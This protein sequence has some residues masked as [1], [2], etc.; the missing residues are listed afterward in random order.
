MDA[1][2]PSHEI[3]PVP[4]PESLG[5]FRITIAFVIISIAAL[6][7]A[8]FV[9]DRLAQRIGEDA[10]VKA[11]SHVASLQSELIGA[12][13]SQTLQNAAVGNESDDEHSAGTDSHE[14]DDGHVDNTEIALLLL[15]AGDFGGNLPESDVRHLSL[16]DPSGREIWSSGN[17]ASAASDEAIEEAISGHTIGPDFHFDA[18]L[19][20]G[21]ES[22]AG[23]SVDVVESFVP[24]AMGNGSPDLLLHVALDV[25]DMLDAGISETQSAVRN[26]TAMALGSVLAMMSAIVFIGD[27]RLSNKS[28]ELIKRE[29]L[30]ARR[31]DD[32]NRELQRIDRAK[33]EFLSSVSHELKTPLAVVLGFTR[34][35]KG[36]KRNNL[37]ERDIRQLATIERNGWRLNTLIDDLLELSRIET[38]R[39]RLHKE[40]VDIKNVLEEIATSFEPILD[41]RVQ[42]LTLHPH[43]GPAWLEADKGRLIQVLTNIVSNAGKY[44]DSGTEITLRSEI[45]EDEAILSVTDQGRGMKPEDLENLFSLFFRSQDAED[46]ATPGMGIGLYISRKIVELHGG[47]ISVESTYGSGTTMSVRLPG[48]TAEPQSGPITRPRFANRLENLPDPEPGESPGDQ[49]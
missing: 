47:D 2:V 16:H 18:P 49:G 43:E 23:E 10:A 44:S 33:N 8:I 29:R 31:L 7:L 24:I 15:G 22:D 20:S 9:I 36:N 30:V 14:H 3:R 17:K 21:R 37:D 42:T 28:A 34:I 45:R 46:S 25:T 1:I 11:A 6:I 4:I 39:I 35:V 13:F 38:K 48:V 5:R 12:A 40:S 19:G 27:I 26:V 41:G 32:E